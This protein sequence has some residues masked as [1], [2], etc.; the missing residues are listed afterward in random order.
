MLQYVSPGGVRD[1]A[2]EILRRDNALKYYGD[3][4]IF[5]EFGFVHILFLYF[6]FQIRG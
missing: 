2:L 1:E 5:D 3:G 6:S 4:T